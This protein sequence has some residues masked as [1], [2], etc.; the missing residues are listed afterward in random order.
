MAKAKK[1]AGNKQC[2]ICK[3]EQP[4]ENQH[5]VGCKAVFDNSPQGATAATPPET[6]AED[7]TETGGEDSDA[8][9]GDENDAET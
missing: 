2:P 8:E 3:M 4:A 9:N 6:D 5:C 1:S 7:V